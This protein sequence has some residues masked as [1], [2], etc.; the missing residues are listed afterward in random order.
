[1]IV[2]RLK[3]CS[4][5]L[6]PFEGFM[7]YPRK[8]EETVSPVPLEKSISDYVIRFEHV[9]FRYPGQEQYALRDVSCEIQ[10][11]KSSIRENIVMDQERAEEERISEALHVTGFDEKIEK[12][13]NGLDTQ[14]YKDFDAEGIEL[15]GGEAQ[16]LAICRAYY[17][18]SPICI[19]DEPTAALDP[20]AECEIYDN[21]QALVH[22]KTAFFISHRLA[23]SRICERVL[24]FCNGEL[25]EDGSHTQLMEQAGSYYELFSMQAQYFYEE[26]T[27]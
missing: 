18:N 1:M 13:K 21:F 25:V 7:R 11:L 10:L 24:V 26:L 27:E 6:K 5:Y 8:L 16:K 19:L 14:V 22:G 20:K 2:G 12:W 3:Q 15:S 9:Y 4:I 23:S 17:K